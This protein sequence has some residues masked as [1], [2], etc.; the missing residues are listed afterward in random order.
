MIGHN[1]ANVALCDS[2]H[3]RT[4]NAEVGG[5]PFTSAGQRQD[6]APKC[7]WPVRDSAAYRRSLLR[8]FSQ[9]GASLWVVGPW[10]V[11]V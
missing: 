3:S 9:I 11:N 4:E 7:I 2:R 6:E 10:G 1:V 8:D 5:D